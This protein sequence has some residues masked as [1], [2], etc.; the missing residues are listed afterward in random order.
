MRIQKQPKSKVK[1]AIVTLVII[2]LPLLGYTLYAQANNL[3]PFPA[4][5]AETNTPRETNSVDYSGPTNEDVE[6]SQDAKEKL[7]N[8][9]DNDSQT[10]PEDNSPSNDSQGK[11][12]AAVTISFADIYNDNLEIRAFTPTVIEGSG[13]CTATISKQGSPSITKTSQAFID[14]SSSIC[15]PIYIPKSQL[16]SGTW[17]VSV[18]Y[19]SKQYQG[20]S[21][22][23]TVEVK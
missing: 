7:L 15:Q 20:S 8:K 4:Q 23:M 3:W 22:Q 5:S 11:K 14:S 16:T 13:T 12:G 19:S 9:G 10:Q 2:A 17:N 6:H 1:I 18:T 21:G